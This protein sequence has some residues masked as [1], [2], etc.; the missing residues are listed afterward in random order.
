M[1]ESKVV[2]ADAGLLE[3]SDAS[4]SQVIDDKRLFGL[5]INGRN[6]MQLVSLSVGV[7]NG[8]RAIA[9]QGQANVVESR[10][11]GGLTEEEIALSGIQSF[12][13]T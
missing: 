12:P 13:L 4:L 10:Y 9:T 5:P 3:A 7:M 6:L 1:N 11:F 8:G 2:Q